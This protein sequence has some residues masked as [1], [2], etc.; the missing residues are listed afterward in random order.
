VKISFALYHFSAVPKTNSS[1]T[2]KGDCSSDKDCD[3][4]LYCYQRFGFELIPGCA[5]QGAYQQDYC[6][7]PSDIPGNDEGSVNSSG[8]PSGEPPNGSG[9][10]G[11]S[12]PN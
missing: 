10:G 1:S 9:P 12:G 2:S 6:F 11:P 8:G 3:K 5:G 4:N 7:D